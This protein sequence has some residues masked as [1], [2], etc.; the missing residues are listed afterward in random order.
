MVTNYGPNTN[1]TNTLNL[2]QDEN[3]LVDCCFQKHSLKT[4][5]HLYLFDL[6]QYIKI[7]LKLVETLY[8]STQYNE[9]INK[10]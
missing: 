5:S 1:D 6:D 8:H 10:F 4:F 9:N 3:I 2:V 7:I